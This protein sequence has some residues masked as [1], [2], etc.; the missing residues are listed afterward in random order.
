MLLGWRWLAGAVPAWLR[1]FVDA[2]EWGRV[3]CLIRAGVRGG[4]SVYAQHSRDES[5]AGRRESACPPWTDNLEEIPKCRNVLFSP[6]C[7]A[8]IRSMGSANG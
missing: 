7:V 5:G 6:M 3:N 8:V 2:G 4:K 1:G